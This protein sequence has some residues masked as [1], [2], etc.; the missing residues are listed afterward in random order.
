MKQVVQASTKNAR[1]KLAAAA[2]LAAF[3][4]FVFSCSKPDQPPSTTTESNSNIQ[5]TVEPT[6]VNPDEAQ[7][8]YSQFDHSS[9]AHTRMP[10]LLC[11]QRNTNATQISFPGSGGH[12]PCIGCHQQQFSAGSGAPICTI[13]HTDAEKGAMK[14]F[15]S[16]RSFGRQ[17]SHSS[18]LRVSCSVCHK[19]SQRGVALSIPSGA[20]AHATCFSCHTASSSNEM[21]S[22]SACHQP[23]QL[24]RTSENVRA[25]RVSFSHARHT[26]EGLNCASCHNV[27]AGTTGR[28]VSAPLTA[29]HHAPAG[30]ASCAACHNGKR[31]FGAND[32]QNCK[33]C[34][35][36][37][38]FAF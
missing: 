20:N 1:R 7:L 15:S 4:L 6:A 37:N 9:Q 28:Q 35:Q 36:G 33:R 12:T 38:T 10:C 14:G 11:H 32:F 31:A 26:R 19:Q 18:H 5:P 22:C 8:D 13:C 24:V 17:F 16:L 30:A 34:H 27:R 29:M 3:V 2:G 21:A 23:G 25:F